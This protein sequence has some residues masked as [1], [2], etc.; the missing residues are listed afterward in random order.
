MLQYQVVISNSRRKKFVLSVAEH[1][2]TELFLLMVMK[3]QWFYI[4]KGYFHL[5]LVNEKKV[6]KMK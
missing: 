3:K 1:Y 6:P 5:S 4:E 2:Y